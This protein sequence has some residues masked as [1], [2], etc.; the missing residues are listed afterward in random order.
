MVAAKM[1]GEHMDTLR[2]INQSTALQVIRQLTLFAQESDLIII[3]LKG[4]VIT[5]LNRLTVLLERREDTL[6]TLRTHKR[7]SEAGNRCKAD[8]LRWQTVLT[9]SETPGM[10]AHF[11]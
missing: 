3:A 4:T 5:L 11:L 1:Y 8:A 7:L 10:I 9:D 6:M 2:C